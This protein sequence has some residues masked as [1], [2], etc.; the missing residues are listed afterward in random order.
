[1]KREI[2]QE[3]FD[4]WMKRLKLAAIPL[5]SDYLDLSLAFRQRLYESLVN[6]GW[7]QSQSLIV[8]AS[9]DPK[10]DNQIINGKH[11]VIIISQILMDGH[12]FDIASILI[13]RVPID[14]IDEL[15]AKRASSEISASLSK[16]PKLSAK[17]VESNIRTI[18]QGHVQE[19][20]V[21]ILD[22]LHSCGF[23]NDSIS[24]VLID[25]ELAKLEKKRVHHTKQAEKKKGRIPD[26]LKTQPW[27]GP[28]PEIID[29]A[30][31]YIRELVFKCEH[32]GKENKQHVNIACGYSG[33]LIKFAI[34]R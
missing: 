24:Q 23:N 31:S 15:R 33:D 29:G 34:A 11:R 17:W 32:C 3:L 18:V 14:T 21:K 16:S 25:V 20:T 5:D 1:M 26:E 6:N 13:R 8:A 19:G 12:K 2:V 22:Y 27:N 7:D 4:P 10:I 28:R 30:T 9:D